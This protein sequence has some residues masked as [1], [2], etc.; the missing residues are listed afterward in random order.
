MLILD[1][2][3]DIESRLVGALKADRWVR[4]VA[5]GLGVRDPALGVT[6]GGR[7]E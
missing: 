5:G 2:V 3:G 7:N 6:L 4:P 1:A